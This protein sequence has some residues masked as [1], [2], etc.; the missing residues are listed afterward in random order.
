MVSHYCFNL[1]ISV[2]EAPQKEQKLGKIFLQKFI[3]SIK[4]HKKYRN[5]AWMK[6]RKKATLLQNNGGKEKQEDYPTPAVYVL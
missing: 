2:S 6:T 1:D 5:K 4:F 3:N